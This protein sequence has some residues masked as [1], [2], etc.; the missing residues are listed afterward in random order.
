MKKATRI[1]TVMKLE[2]VWPLAR[3]EQEAGYWKIGRILA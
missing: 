3:T 2:A 1:G